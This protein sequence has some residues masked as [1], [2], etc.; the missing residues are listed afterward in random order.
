MYVHMVS[1]CLPMDFKPVF[2][3][4]SPDRELGTG[5]CKTAPWNRN[6]SKRQ[7]IQCPLLWFHGRACGGNLEVLAGHLLVLQLNGSAGMARSH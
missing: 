2:L 3:A 7:G 6:R 5:Q 4:G 1:L